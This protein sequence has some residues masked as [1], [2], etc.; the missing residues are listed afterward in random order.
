MVLNWLPLKVEDKLL[1]DSQTF[2]F[3]LYRVF[4]DK[5]K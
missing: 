1:V 5:I 3:E 4:E 2:I